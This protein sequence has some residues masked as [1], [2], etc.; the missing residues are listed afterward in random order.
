MS[1]VTAVYEIETALPPEQAAAVMA[2]EQSSGTFVAVARE[3]DELK[4]RFAARVTDALSTGAPAS[5][6][7]DGHDLV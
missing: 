4:R 1:T 3:T 7:H 6:A 5:R 2:G